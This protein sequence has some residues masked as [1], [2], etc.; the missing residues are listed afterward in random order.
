M[1]EATRDGFFSIIPVKG[2]QRKW[3]ALVQGGDLSTLHAATDAWVARRGFDDNHHSVEFDE[4]EYA[5]CRAIL[6]DMGYR[7]G[8][9]VNYQ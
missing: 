5:R 9:L 3:V 7:V 8:Q 4:Q 1:K 6:L 2:S